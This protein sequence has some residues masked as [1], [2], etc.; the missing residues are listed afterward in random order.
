MLAE[1]RHHEQPGSTFNNWRR[2]YDSYAEQ[3]DAVTQ[4]YGTAV[5]A[6]YTAAYWSWPTESHLGALYLATQMHP[7]NCH[8]PGTWPATQ[9][10]TRY[11]AILWQPD[12]KTI[13]EPEKLFAVETARPIWWEKSVYRRPVAKGE[14]LLVHLVNSPE[15]ETVDIKREIVPPAAACKVTLTIPE[16]KKVR[17]VWVLEPRTKPLDDG[18]ATATMTLEPDGKTWAH[19]TGSLCRT[20]PSQVEL[21]PVINGDRATVEVPPFHYYS[22]VVFRLEK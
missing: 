14:D 7:C 11:S 6:G 21:K 2:C 5:T 19:K 3:R 18:G 13:K 8:Q 17:S 22:L 20:G 12:V 10:M 16:K 9:F 15:T 4:R 1:F